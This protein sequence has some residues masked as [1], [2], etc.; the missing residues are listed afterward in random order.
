M[1]RTTRTL[2]AFLLLAASSAACAQDSSLFFTER[3]AESQ[4]WRTVDTTMTPEEYETAY[5]R[6]LRLVRNTLKSYSQE[7]FASIG[8][9]EAGIE[10]M[11]AA[12]GLAVRDARFHLNESKTLALE[13]KDVADEDRT[14]FL[15]IRMDW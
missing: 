5:R 12:V 4:Q 13:L 1:N 2:S 10:F 11:G 6:N 8:V 3:T 15:G 14:L 9:P 7:A